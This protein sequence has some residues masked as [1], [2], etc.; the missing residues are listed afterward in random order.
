VCRYIPTFGSLSN[1]TMEVTGRASLNKMVSMLLP[2]LEGWI[3]QFNKIDDCPQIQ[4]IVDNYFICGRF[5]CN[6]CL[7]RPLLR[8]ERNFNQTLRQQQ[9]QAYLES[10]RADEEKERR[11]C[12]E[13]E[14]REGEERQ[15]RERELEEQHHKE[16][17]LY[18]IYWILMN[19]F[20]IYIY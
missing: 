10:L 12:E 8:I 6:S 5:C 20:W 1:N 3:K 19:T 9:D 11:R 15:Q 16:V 13:R 7:F 4:N 14:R 17:C 2:V 18:I